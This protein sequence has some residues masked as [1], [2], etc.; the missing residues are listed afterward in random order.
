MYYKPSIL[1]CLEGDM[2]KGSGRSVPGFDL[3]NALSKC[4]N[5][6]EKFGGHSMAI[7]IS[8][9]KENFEKLK[10]EIEKC[11]EESNI[12]DIMPIIN[13]DKRINLKDISIEEAKSLELLE[14]FGEANKMP[15]F[16]M[17]NLKIDS[18]RALSD[19]KHLKLTLKQD[20]C[21]F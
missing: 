2:G 17:Q 13:I 21:I 14:P 1:I 4:N 15:I 5:Y 19:G 16:L 8:I 20:N 7:G 9:K 10:A 12:S 3:Y 6:I 18:I 11:A